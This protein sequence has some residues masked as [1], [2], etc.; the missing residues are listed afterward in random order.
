M[1]RHRF[2][3]RPAAKNIRPIRIDGS[4]STLCNSHASLSLAVVRA[5]RI[6]FW[7]AVEPLIRHPNFYPPCQWDK[8]LSTLRP[9]FSLLKGTM[10]QSSGGSPTLPA[11]IQ[12][13]IQISG[14]VFAGSTAVR[15][16]TCFWD[17]LSHLRSDWL[18][19]FKQNFNL[20]TSVYVVSRVASSVYVLGF[21]LFATYPLPACNTAFVVF[22]CFYPISVS[23]SAFLFFS[24]VRAIYGGNR[25]VTFVFGFLWLAVLGSS[26]TIPVSGGAVSLGDP[27][28]CLIVG[29][30]APYVTASSGIIIT[31]NDTLVFFTISHHLVSNY[32]H[33]QQLQTCGDWIRA[34]LG[35]SDLP[36]FS[37]ALL[38]DGQ[39]YYIIT[40]AT[41]ILT[42]L[43]VFIPGVSLVYRGMFVIPNVALT[44][45]MA[46]RVYRN[47]RLGITSGSGELSLPTLNSLDPSI[48]LSVVDFS[49]HRNATTHSSAHLED[50]FN[51]NK[52]GMVYPP[53]TVEISSLSS[54]QGTSRNLCRISSVT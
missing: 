35:G 11:N 40:V 10:S 3:L 27:P 24:R 5:T 16:Q 23:A 30:H 12:R 1:D 13:E 52:S 45:I 7:Q 28:E 49:T 53:A 37:K 25:L 9:Q 17:I 47:T 29:P 14:Y 38:T 42:T 34:L 26:I 50:D 6:T 41:N 36:A 46:C 51:R 2:L 31:V 39:M 15:D 43:L 20:N 22:N 44:S 19:L 21:T 4:Y 8:N 33:T 32:A 18:L 48:P 54:G